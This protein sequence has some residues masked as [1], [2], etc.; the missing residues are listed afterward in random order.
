MDDNKWRFPA[1]G[2]GEESGMSSDEGDEFKKSPY[3]S[4]AR[5]IIQNSIDA[6][7][8]DEEPVKVSFKEFKIKTKSILGLEDYKTAIRRSIKFWEHKKEY[9]KI[10]NEILE[11]LDNEYIDCLRISDSNTK[12]LIGIYSDEKKGNSFLALTKGK[13]VSEKSDGVTGG[14]K[15][16]GKNAAFNFSKLKLIFY[17]TRTIN[18]EIGTIGVAKLASGYL[19]DNEDDKNRD[20]TQGVG[21]YGSDEYNSAINKLYTFDESYN[22]GD[23]SGTDIYIFGFEKTDSWKKQVV[24][25]LLDSFMAAF[26]RGTLEV[27]LDDLKI[28]KETVSD[29]IESDIISEENKNN[30]ISQYRI[31]KG[32]KNVNVFDI[33]T[34]YGTVGLYVLTFDEDE[35]NLSTHRC[36]MI[37]HPLMKIKHY[38]LN[39]SFR[40]SAMCFIGNDTLG[41]LLLSIEN[42]PHTDWET[43][44]LKDK[45]M[46]KEVERVLSEIRTEITNRVVECLKLGDSD[47]IDPYGAGDF[48][49]EDEDGTGGKKEKDSPKQFKIVTRVSSRKE[50]KIIEKRT[51]RESDDG[52]GVSPTI[53]TIAEDEGDVEYPVGNNKGHGGEPHPGNE[54]GNEKEGDSIIF[55]KDQLAG[56]RYKVISTDKKQGKLRIV[57]YSPCNHEKCYLNIALIDDSNSRND[58]LINSMIFNGTRITCDNTKEYGPFAIKLN[59]KVVLDVET[60]QQ[61]YFASEVK[62]ICK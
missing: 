29:L 53:G 26:M 62:I 51:S 4:L 31:L 12:G 3:Q 7:Y 47:P 23:K 28:N 57:F 50:N 25:S 59:Q 9:V 20:Y 22:R 43:K 16:S 34:D 30:V 46:K 54:T 55:K 52:Q 2:H 32:G 18:N 33:D 36:E 58:V 48:L 41:K 13:G 15:G 42:K 39:P 19:D 6:I 44:R 11:Y 37:R 35:E 56:V 24:N 14:S 27:E 60:N 17:S 10:Y 45:G 1:S 5:E 49:P 61:G 38:N 40:A 21:Y 8:S